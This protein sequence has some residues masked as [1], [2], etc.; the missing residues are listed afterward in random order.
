MIKFFLHH[1]LLCIIYNIF[2]VDDFVA[3]EARADLV[4]EHAA[5]FRRSQIGGGGFT[6]IIAKAKSICFRR[7]TK[8]ID[9]ITGLVD[10]FSACFFRCFFEKPLARLTYAYQVPDQAVGILQYLKNRPG[11]VGG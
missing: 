9:D 1:L 7:K 6:A 8:I 3:V 2:L 4:A 11:N 10:Y 5:Q